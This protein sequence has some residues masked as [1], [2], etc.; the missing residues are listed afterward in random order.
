MGASPVITLVPVPL[1]RERFAPYGDVIETSQRSSAAMNDGRFERFD[2]LG[3][4]DVVDGEVAISVSR[5]RTPTSLP[6]RVYRVERHPLGSQAF[7][8]LTPCRMIVVV[9]PPGEAVMADELR[10]FVTNGRQGLNYGRG[11]WHMPLVAFEA[12]QE[13]LIVDRAG[14]KGNCEEHEFDEVVMLE[15]A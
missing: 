5:C 10:A 2:E 9:A 15:D 13:F 4:V 3:R 6:L 11:T 1:T 8:P 7:V 12:G 14:E